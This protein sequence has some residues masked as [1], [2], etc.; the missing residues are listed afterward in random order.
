VSE[1]NAWQW[2]RKAGVVFG[3]DLH[4]ER[5]EN[6]AGAGGP[7]VQ[8]M[9]KGQP[10]LIELKHAALPARGSTPLRFGSPIRPSQVEWA[11]AR[12]RAGGNVWYL[13]S[14]GK[15]HAREFYLL[16]ARKHLTNLQEGFG[17]DWLRY[18][19]VLDVK[20]PEQ[21]VYYCANA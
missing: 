20:S 6:M 17:M 13:I 16:S 11:K 3:D 18:N 12:V 1:S 14:V 2:L 21:V 4:L 10:V 15:G 8:G 19:S 5:V 7:D 9:L